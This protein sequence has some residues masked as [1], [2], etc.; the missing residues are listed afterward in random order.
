[1]SGPL[2]RLIECHSIKVAPLELLRLGRLP[3]N[4][5]PG[6][7]LHWFFTRAEGNFYEGVMVTGVTSDEVDER[8]QANIISVGYKA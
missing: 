4:S 6:F 1:M 3:V 8:V 7:F 2:S 5:H